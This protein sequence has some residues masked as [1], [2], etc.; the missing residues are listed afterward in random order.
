[1]EDLLKLKGKNIV[2]MGVANERSIAWGVARSLYKVGAN[3]IFTYR[4]ERSLGRINKMLADNGYEAKMV[5]ECDVNNDESIKKAF[6]T[7][8]QEVGTIHGVVHSVAFAN[9]DDL[10]GQFIDTS[11]D[12]YA[13]A[14]DTSAYSLI[15]VA[16]EAKPFMTEG[17]SIIT[18]SYLGAERVVE[19]YNV[20]AIAKASLEASVKYLTVDLG[21]DNIRIN[22]ISAGAIR[23]LAAK[24]VPSFNKILHKIEE[25]APL[26]RNV[27]QEE[28]GDMSVAFLSNLSR[29]VTGEVIYVD[30]GYNI[31]G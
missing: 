16:R 13:F 23:T 20:M 19:G 27:T 10:K 28:V 21:K 18:M 12:G 1:M 11:R 4:K 29:G 6:T 26:K 25:T 8:G 22:A 24:G 14:Q 3:L 9:A 15:A 2:V 30:S 5:V 7:I 17:G 31:M